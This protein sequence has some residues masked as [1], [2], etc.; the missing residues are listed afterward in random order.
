MTAV[1]QTV[2][3]VGG[4]RM[5]IGIAHAF[6]TAGATVIVLERDELA[7]ATA[8][9]SLHRAIDTSLERGTASES[10][11]GLLARTSTTIETDDLA[12]A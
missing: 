11:A 10:R 6:L 9:E 7:A 1:P 12:P 3:V 8:T 4:G 2:G 5:G